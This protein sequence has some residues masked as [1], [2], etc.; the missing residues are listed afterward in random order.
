M[1]VNGFMLRVK[2]AMNMDSSDPKITLKSIKYGSFVKV[3]ADNHPSW[4]DLK[5]PESEFAK[6]ILKEACYTD[7]QE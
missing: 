1:D 3:M 5:N 2:E 6:F 4:S 7:D